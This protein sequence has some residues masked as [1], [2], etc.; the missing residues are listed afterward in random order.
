[1][2]AWER[3]FTDSCRVAHLGTTRA[4]GRP[5]IVPVCFARTGDRFVTPVDEKPKRSQS[6]ARATNIERDPR[7]TMLWDCYDEDWR[8][9]AWV[10]ADGV[11]AVVGQGGDLPEALAALRARYP[12]YRSMALE[13]LPLIVFEPQRVVSWRWNTGTDQGGLLFTL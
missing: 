7:C 2:L 5:H 3:E 1:M 8:Q 10:R 12:Q 11:A 13:R 6:L 9:L 4:D